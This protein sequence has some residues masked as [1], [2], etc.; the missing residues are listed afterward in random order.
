MNYIE[1]GHIQDHNSKYKDWFIG[2][3]VE[4]DQFFYSEGV[5]NFEVKLKGTPFLRQQF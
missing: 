5:S 2:S 4:S 1:H 3:F